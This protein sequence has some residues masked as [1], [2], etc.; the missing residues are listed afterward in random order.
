MSIKRIVDTALWT[1]P[2][3]VDKYSPEDRYFFLYIL[4]N[5]HTTQL[6]IYSLP[7]KFIAFE[8]GYS[9]ES[10]MA[11][12][13]RFQSKYKN[14]I[15]SEKTQEISIINS[16]KFSIVKGGKPVEDLLKK[17]INA[18][19]DPSLIQNTYDHLQDHW[20]KSNKPF[21]G[22]VMKIFK[23]EMEKRKNASLNDNDNDN[24]NENENEDSYHD[25]YHDSFKVPKQADSKPIRKTKSDK[26]IRNKHGEYGHV[27]L[28]ELQLSKLISDFSKEKI[29]EYIKRVDEYCQQFNKKYNDCNL[30][31]RSWI[32]KD[33]DLGERKP[34]GKKSEFNNYDQRT[35]DYGDLERK[36]L[37]GGE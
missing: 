20:A 6:G 22:T 27:F 37:G 8:M 21:D 26:P 18:I 11:M 9:V 33:A 13:E 23:D 35:Y 24:D 16:L 34:V 32:K 7:K 30:T 3:V 29:D 12:L 36:L 10:V 31:I 5:P 17:E 1:D 15:Y 28:T 14:I 19:K 25:S 4:T 2:T